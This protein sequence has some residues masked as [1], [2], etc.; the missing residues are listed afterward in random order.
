MLM[1]PV[2][3][4]KFCVF[5]FSKSDLSSVY[6]HYI[7]ITLLIF[8]TWL[9]ISREKKKKRNDPHIREKGGGVIK[10]RD[11]IDYGRLRGVCT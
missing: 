1:S 2:R 11:P 4:F 8:V 9:Y 6:S 3:A 7:F 5:F 10:L